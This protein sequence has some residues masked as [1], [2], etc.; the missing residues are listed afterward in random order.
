MSK[1]PK[2]CAFGIIAFME[3]LTCPK[4]IIEKDI[5]RNVLFFLYGSLDNGFYTKRC[6]VQGIERLGC[7]LNIGGL[8]AGD[9]I[10]I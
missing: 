1:L 8:R 9:V 3:Y 2:E 4:R 6:P 5:D 7:R 10:S